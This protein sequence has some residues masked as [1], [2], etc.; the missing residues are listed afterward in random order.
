MRGALRARKTHVAALSPGRQLRTRLC[1]AMMACA[2]VVVTLPCRAGARSDVALPRELFDGTY[3]GIRAVLGSDAPT[4]NKLE[5]DGDHVHNC[6]NIL[7]HVTNFGLI[8]SRPRSTQRYSGAPSAQWPKGSTTEYLDAAGL[9]IGAVKG[10]EQHVTTGVDGRAPG[11]FRPGLSNLDRIYETRE[12]AL[13]G[14]RA[15][16]PNADDDRDGKVDED[17]LDGRDNDHDGRI[18]EDFAAVSNQEFFCEY[19]DTDP[20]IRRIAPE[21]VPL[22]L[23]VQQASLC[24]EAPLVDDFIAF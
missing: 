14:A 9:W 13:G 1:R 11:E 15:P 20:T 4:T 17:W 10:V 18:D 7:L 22:E 19:G 21:H 16:A 23:W 5:L 24:W 2:F 8:G 12:G 6:G 3:G